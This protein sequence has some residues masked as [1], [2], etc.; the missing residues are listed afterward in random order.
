MLNAEKIKPYTDYLIQQRVEKTMAKDLLEHE[1]SLTIDEKRLI[2][3]YCYPRQLGDRELP[4]R[5]KAS[6]KKRGPIA[7]SGFLEPD[8]LETSLIIEAG[9]TMQYER[10]IKHLMH[11]FSDPQKVCQITGT[12]VLECPICGK[13]VRELNIWDS[14]L[15]HT[16][17]H[18]A[19]GSPTETSIVLC[20]DC[21]IQLVNASDIMQVLDP[22]YLDWTKRTFNTNY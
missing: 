17:E 4:D 13:K 12:D 18:L 21:L 14:T 7:R 5:V 3:M 22:G 15:D 11:S 16:K 20:V 1:D 6:R 9:K 10:F 19:Y 2:Y 8:D